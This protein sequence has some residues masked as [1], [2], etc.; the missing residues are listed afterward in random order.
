MMRHQLKDIKYQQ[1]K[2]KEE[3]VRLCYKYENIKEKMKDQNR[4]LE[5]IR[6]NSHR[7]HKSRST[8]KVRDI[9]YLSKTAFSD[10]LNEVH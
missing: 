8:S 9:E 10:F 5:K 7:S 2:Y 4:L 3:T 1:K 6:A